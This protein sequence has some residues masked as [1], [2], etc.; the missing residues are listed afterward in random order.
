MYQKSDFVPQSE[1]MN[2]F[3]S[4]AIIANE[5][6]PIVVTGSIEQKEVTPVES[7]STLSSGGLVGTTE[8]VQV[9]LYT[10]EVSSTSDTQ[11]FS[12]ISVTEEV[13]TGTTISPV[14]QETISF[15]GETSD[16]PDIESGSTVTLP[17]NT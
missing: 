16:T 13:S 8:E 2:T 5:P 1:P 3:V 12:N 6:N 11:I 7:G 4:D 14:E 9:G 15:S 17:D 10:G